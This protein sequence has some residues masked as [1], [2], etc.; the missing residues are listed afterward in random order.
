MNTL[1]F[2][3]DAQLLNKAILK[4]FKTALSDLEI[5]NDFI[6]I[7]TKF[8]G[9]KL[10]V[11]IFGQADLT[12]NLHWHVVRIINRSIVPTAPIMISGNN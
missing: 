11:R 4:R 7:S 6:E 5:E 10:Q 8:N 1:Y 3:K 12:G 9:L 2:S